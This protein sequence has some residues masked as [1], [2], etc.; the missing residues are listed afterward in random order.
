MQKRIGHVALHAS[1]FANHGRRLPRLVVLWVIWSRQALF[2]GSIVIDSP[3]PV[4]VSEFQF[5]QA[6][7]DHVWFPPELYDPSSVLGEGYFIE[8]SCC[9]LTYLL[10]QIEYQFRV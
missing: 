8:T 7:K 9:D 5:P 1:I 4:A 6:S 3:S 2:L 10:R